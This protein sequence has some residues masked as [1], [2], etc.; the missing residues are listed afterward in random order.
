[1]VI[2][3][4]K[5]NEKTLSLSKIT[6]EILKYCDTDEALKNLKD[7]WSKF[8]DFKSLLKIVKYYSPS[9]YDINKTNTF[10]LN[11]EL[12]F[13]DKMRKMLSSDGVSK[14]TDLGQKDKTNYSFLLNEVREYFDVITKELFGKNLSYDVFQKKFVISYEKQND[15][16]N[17]SINYI[18]SGS[19]GS[20]KINTNILV[21]FD[22]SRIST[23]QASYNTKLEFIWL[24]Y[25]LDLVSLEEFLK[26]VLQ[27]LKR[28][29]KSKLKNFAKILKYNGSYPSGLFSKQLVEKYIKENFITDGN[30]SFVEVTDRNIFD[31]ILKN[32]QDDYFNNILK[33]NLC[34][35]K[36]SE[37]QLFCL[38]TYQPDLYI[39]GYSN[40]DDTNKKLMIRNILLKWSNNENFNV[41]DL[42]VD[43]IKNYFTDEE[44]FI[45]FKSRTREILEGIL[46]ESIYPHFLENNLIK[47]E[48]GNYICVE[49]S[50]EPTPLDFS[51][52]QRSELKS[53]FIPILEKIQDVILVNFTGNTNKYILQSVIDPRLTKKEKIKSL[54]EN[55]NYGEFLKWI[56]N[57]LDWYPSRFLLIDKVNNLDLVNQNNPEVIKD[58]ELYRFRKEV[59]SLLQ[60]KDI[61][62]FVGVDYVSCCLV[63]QRPASTYEYT[64]DSDET[65]RELLKLTLGKDI[66]FLEYA[67]ENLNKDVYDKSKNTRIIS[68]NSPRIRI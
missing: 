66:E 37:Q 62:E 27:Q 18:Y 41:R 25:L 29:A 7:E 53:E 48:N 56:F 2:S 8:K 23:M 55:L 42:S 28:E 64:I 39:D 13:L 5:E 38:M 22:L 36:L 30:R 50:S 47:L 65:F 32:N 19:G 54:L 12:S 40:L 34:V 11:K 17:Q 21:L 33:E 20:E 51:K 14:W 68:I 67:C 16:N 1:M 49:N 31:I 26:E 15:Y 43:L 52:T 44:V 24:K 4:K 61:L 10:S 45:A 58:N 3:V 63:E 57:L 9:Y 59:T 6:R 35:S 60:F 46:S